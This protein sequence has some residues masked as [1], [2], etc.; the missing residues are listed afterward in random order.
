MSRRGGFARLLRGAK[1]VLPAAVVL[2]W[3]LT[4]L[5]QMVQWSVM[6]ATPPRPHMQ[7]TITGGQTPR[8]ARDETHFMF[9]QGGVY[10]RRMMVLTES[11]DATRADANS[12][13]LAWATINSQ[14]PGSAPLQ[15]QVLGGGLTFA[16]RM[17]VLA[18]VVT[19]IWAAAAWW[20]SRI[21]PPGHCLRCR[22][23]LQS[24][25]RDTEGRVLCPECGTLQAPS[26]G[27]LATS[28]N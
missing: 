7:P 24:T 16:V 2:A 25:T 1:W 26:G 3:L 8:V 27:D 10:L 20:A 12:R 22:Y 14:F 6:S 11:F 17:W 28:G 23:D 13:K 15:W 18:I 21:V 4:G 19:A 5:S 9:G